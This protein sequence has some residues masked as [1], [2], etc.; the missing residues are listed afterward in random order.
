MTKRF[1]RKLFGSI[2]L[3]FLHA[4]VLHGQTG[5]KLS[6][7]TP[8]DSGIST[9]AS[10]LGYELGTYFSYYGEVEK[11]IQTVAGQTDRVRLVPYGETYERRTLYLLIFSSPANLARLDSIQRDLNRLTEPDQSDDIKAKAIIERSPACVWLSYN[12][13]GNEAS[14]SEAALGLIYHLAAAK[15]EETEK[16]LE[17]LVII[18]DPMVNPDGRERYA[19]WVNSATGSQ[20]NENVHSEEHHEPWPGG[21]FN[22]YLFDLNRDWSWAT[23]I[24]TQSR[25]KHYNAWLPVFHGDYHEMGAS[26]SY[27]FFPPTVPIN[28]FMPVEQ[29]TRWSTI[30]GKAYAKTFDEKGWRYF[31]GESFDLLYPGYGDSWP[32]LNGATGMT[33]EQ[34]GGGRAGESIA[35][36]HGDTLTLYDRVLHHFSTSLITLET[37]AK[38]RKERLTDYYHFWRDAIAEAR[39]QSFT[40][41]L[42]D[43][44]ADPNQAADFIGMLA[45]QGIDVYQTQSTFKTNA[46]NYMDQGQS[47]KTFPPGSYV[48]PLAQKKYRLLRALLQLETVTADTFF[49]DVAA[50]SPALSHNVNLYTVSGDVPVA[51]GKITGRPAVA[52]TVINGPASVAYLFRWNQSGAVSALAALWKEA[53]RVSVATAP[54]TLNG[55]SFEEGTMIIFVSGNP[56]KPI[57]QKMKALASTHGIKIHSAN[58]A[59]TEIG[60]DLGSSKIKP[61]KPPRIAV[62]SGD[63]VDPTDFGEIWFLFDRMLPYPLDIVGLDR[64]PAL[65]LDLYDVLILPHA[66]TSYKSLIDKKTTRKVRNWI[67][68]GGVFVGLQNG[69]FWATKNQSGLT[70]LLLNTDK[71]KDSTSE[72]SESESDSFLSFHEK[73]ERRK[74]DVVPGSIMKVRIDPTHPVGFGYGRQAM[75]LKLSGTSF[76]PTKSGHTVGYF[77]EKPFVSGYLLNKDLTNL[78]KTAYVVDEPVGKGRLVLFSDNPNFRLFWNNLTRLFMNSVLLLPSL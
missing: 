9:P 23:Q 15:N 71:K 54:F 65:S 18:I 70:D 26:Q 57:D 5:F 51:P 58:S 40:H 32:I 33:F 16:L 34:A 35:L 75:M 22:H 69:A 8:Y 45:G 76:K 31:T 36:D 27:F 7:G 4:A 74:K 49:Y 37:T 61:L 10:V 67:K 19:Q 47:Q 64:L 72:N 11:Y 66:W 43:G 6:P 41:Y 20:P 12:V 59:W 2:F 46:R 63:P 28:T 60:A 13:H 77:S 25:L 30:Y 50:W 68:K 44:S 48:I 52:G 73:Q 21:R 39:K 17:E 3:L 55:E 78:E 14:S 1:S 29:V 56:N 53:Y 38:Y 42:L 24:E 62:I